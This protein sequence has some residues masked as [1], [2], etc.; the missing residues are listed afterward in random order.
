MEISGRILLFNH[1]LVLSL[2][3]HMST[4]TNEF[5]AQRARSGKPLREETRRGFPALFWRAP[6]PRSRQRVPCRGGTRPCTE[7]RGLGFTPL[8]GLYGRTS[9]KDERTGY[10]RYVY[11]VYNR[12]QQ[13]KWRKPYPPTATN[14]I[15]AIIPSA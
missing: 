4:K 9:Q 3:A 15:R 5:E 13:K 2:H 10:Q 1:L 7:T 6:V 11:T 12:R 8:H 14:L